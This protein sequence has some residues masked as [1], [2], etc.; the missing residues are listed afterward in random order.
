MK[1][2]SPSCSFDE[3]M[4]TGPLTVTLGTTVVGELLPRR[5]TTGSYGYGL[6]GK[7]AVPLLNGGTAL[8]QA[9]MCLNVIG[10]RG[11]NEKS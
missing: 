11:Q 9:S 5:F 3:L 7:V 6:N 8:M 4:Q 10:S 2:R 1:N